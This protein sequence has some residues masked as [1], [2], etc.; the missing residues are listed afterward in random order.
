MCVL[1]PLSGALAGQQGKWLVA[2]ATRLLSVSSHSV[3]CV[4][5][6]QVAFEL[7]TLV[8][9]TVQ[10]QR[11]PPMPLVFSLALRPGE[12]LGRWGLLQAPIRVLNWSPSL[13]AKRLCS[14]LAERENLLPPAW[15]SHFLSVLS[16]RALCLAPLGGSQIHHTRHVPLLFLSLTCFAQFVPGGCPPPDSCQRNSRASPV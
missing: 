2:A 6:L 15:A 8:P 3:A 10:G 5:G 9:E 1:P 4:L 12:G 13:G 16:L 7:V 11:S 14:P